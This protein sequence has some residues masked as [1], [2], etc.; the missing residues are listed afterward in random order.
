MKQLMSKQI[1]WH[2]HDVTQQPVPRPLHTGWVT[3]HG[4][5]AL[6]AWRNVWVSAGYVLCRVSIY[7][8]QAMCDIWRNRSSQAASTLHHVGLVFCTAQTPTANLND[9]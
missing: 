6:A 1:K 5:N 4:H 2:K 9:T 8:Y 7:D 3:L